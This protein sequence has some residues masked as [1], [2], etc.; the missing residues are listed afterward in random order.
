MSFCSILVSKQRWKTGVCVFYKI[1]RERGTNKREKYG[2][3]NTEREG[4]REYKRK[5]I[6]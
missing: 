3:R 6:I 1:E 5:C 4:G 2:E